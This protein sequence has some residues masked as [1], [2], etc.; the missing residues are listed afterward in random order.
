MQR[1]FPDD[2]GR[3]AVI[4]GHVHLAA[5][6]LPA[7][8]ECAR[9]GIAGLPDQ[10]LAYRFLA[11]VCLRQGETHRGIEALRTALRIA[12]DDAW[13]RRALADTLAEQDPSEALVHAREAVR[14]SPDDAES[15][16]TLG[17]VLHNNDPDAA[18]RAYRAALTLDPGYHPAQ[19]NLATLAALTKGNWSNATEGMARLLIEF[20]Q[21]E[22]PVIFLDQRVWL[23]LRRMIFVTL[24][25]LVLLG[26]VTALSVVSVVVSVG[27]VLGAVAVARRGLQP[28]RNTLPR[29]GARYLRGFPPRNRI[30][31]A[32]LALLVCIWLVMLATSVADLLGSANA[33][34]HGMGV[35]VGFGLFAVVVVLAW[36]RVPFLARRSRR[37][38][39]SVGQ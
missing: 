29:R 12:P 19:Y 24:G 27:T 26:A 6:R 9:Q 34:F 38:R 15:H 14:L 1:D 5:G 18:D 28:I 11:A 36:V 13:V 31:F 7:A 3:A 17:T 4:L 33:R 39:D 37:L 32:V 16:Y 35:G 30:E 10:A 8:E 22:V 2:A 25:G 23:V 20:P 21:A